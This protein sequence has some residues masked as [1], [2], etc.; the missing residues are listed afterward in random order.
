MSLIFSVVEVFESRWKF[1]STECGSVW[2]F[3][4][5]NA[6][7]SPL[8]K[9]V[10]GMFP[11]F[12]MSYCDSRW[13]LIVIYQESKVFIRRFAEN[14]M[15]D[16][17]FC[18]LPSSNFFARLIQFF[19]QAVSCVWTGFRR[20]KNAFKLLVFESFCRCKQQLAKV[21]GEIGWSCHTVT[22]LFF[23]IWVA[24]RKSWAKCGGTSDT[25]VVKEL[26]LRVV[27]CAAHCWKN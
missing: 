5:M 25:A 9:L 21:T 16:S 1:R 20:I 23:H 15:F 17:T 8:E 10:K 4:T 6:V 3:Y 14:V 27:Y 24:N 2:D 13:I 18:G 7:D 12:S 11:F 26:L 19:N 22:N